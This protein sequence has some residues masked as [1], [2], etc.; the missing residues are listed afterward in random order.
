MHGDHPD[1][2]HSG[3]LMSGQ[4]VGGIVA[5]EGMWKGCVAGPAV[6]CT[7]EVYTRVSAQRP[8]PRDVY[9]V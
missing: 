9:T 8:R 1:V 2:Y 5:V 6:E 3:L 7:Y 4:K